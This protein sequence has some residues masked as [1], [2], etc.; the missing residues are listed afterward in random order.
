MFL[1]TSTSAGPGPG[2][3]EPPADVKEVGGRGAGAA[4]RAAGCPVAAAAARHD[5]A[6]GVP[7][8]LGRSS[9]GVQGLVGQGAVD[10]GSKGLDAGAGAP[11]SSQR[12]HPLRNLQRGP[13]SGTSSAMTSS[14]KERSASKST[15][16]STRQAK[17]PYNESRPQRLDILKKACFFVVFL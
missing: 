4:V 8:P 5:S 14:L 16:C 7:L 3:V 9:A 1:S 17:T 6:V 12:C 2:V 13:M 15:S 10:D 11:S